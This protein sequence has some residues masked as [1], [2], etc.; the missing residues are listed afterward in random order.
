MAVHHAVRQGL[1]REPHPV[2]HE[3]GLDVNPA[4]WSLPGRP[5]SASHITTTARSGQR[6]RS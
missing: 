5:G 1:L 4:R 2:S 3:L 6:T